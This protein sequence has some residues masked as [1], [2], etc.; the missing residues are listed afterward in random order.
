MPFC[1]EPPAGGASAVR[2][3][4]LSRRHAAAGWKELAMRCAVFAAL[5]GDAAVTAGAAV[6]DVSARAP[7]ERRELGTPGVT[8]A[9]CG[10]TWPPSSADRWPAPLWIVNQSFGRVR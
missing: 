6:A 9:V 10:A 4:P 7:R 1:V 2:R 8:C 5:V 3:L